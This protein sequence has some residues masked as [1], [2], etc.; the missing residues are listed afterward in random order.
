MT[1]PCAEDYTG[2]LGHCLGFSSAFSMIQKGLQTIAEVWL[3]PQSSH[4]KL[5]PQCDRVER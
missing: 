3:W 4:K 2:N 5:N 1:N